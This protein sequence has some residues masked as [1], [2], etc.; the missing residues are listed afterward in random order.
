MEST[1][2]FQ[3]I[4]NGNDSICFLDKITHALE[5]KKPKLSSKQA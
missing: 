4:E 3:Y 5:K 2:M 1:V